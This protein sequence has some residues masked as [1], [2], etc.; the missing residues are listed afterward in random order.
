MLSLTPNL[1]GTDFKAKPYSDFS[2][3]VNFISSATSCENTFYKTFNNRFA[4]TDQRVTGS[5]IVY[6]HTH[7][8][9]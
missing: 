1:G 4:L 2:I 7:W 5:I 3:K 8:H 6:D 9:C